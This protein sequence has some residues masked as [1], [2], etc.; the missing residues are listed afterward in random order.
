M[1]YYDIRNLLFKRYDLIRT[2]LNKKWWHDVDELMLHG[3]MELLRRYVE[4]EKCFEIVCWDEE[5]FKSAAKE[6]R[7]IYN[8]WINYP[9]RQKEIEDVL[10]K[11][12]TE[13]RQNCKV[14]GINKK[15]F[16]LFHNLPQTEQDNINHDNLPKL[17]KKL[18]EEE[19]DMLIRL[20]KIRKFLWT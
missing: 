18:L 20:I 13:R 10:D 3:N 5:P 2:G 15:G 12:F 8:W 9:N 6:I 4:D 7:T 11:W 1:R 19:Q 14:S 16:E 17:E